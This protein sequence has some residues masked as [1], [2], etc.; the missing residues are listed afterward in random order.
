MQVDRLI[1]KLKR[2][3]DADF[4]S[5]LEL[6]R[7]A[8]CETWDTVLAGVR[9]KA[10]RYADRGEAGELEYAGPLKPRGKTA[11]RTRARVLQLLHLAPDGT[12]A[13]REVRNVAT[14]LVLRCDDRP[15]DLSWLANWPQLRLVH[16][17]GDATVVG[18][19]PQVTELCVPS[20]GSSRDALRELTALRK[21]L[22]YGAGGAGL[23][24][25]GLIG[26]LESLQVMSESASE[27][28]GIGAVAVPT[29]I[30][31]GA[32]PRRMSVHREVRDLHILDCRGLRELA[33]A[34][35]AVVE[36]VRQ[37]YATEPTALDVGALPALRELHVAP[38][39]DPDVSSLRGA[40]NLEVL[41]VGG[42][43]LRSLS[44]LSDSAVAGLREISVID[45]SVDWAGLASCGRLHTVIAGKANWWDAVPT[46]QELEGL[47]VLNLDFAE[48]EDTYPLRDLHQLTHISMRY[49]KGFM[50][51]DWLGHL[52]GL[53]E[54]DL[55]GSAM[56]RRDLSPKLRKSGVR[57]IL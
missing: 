20:L 47:R 50:Q 19:A 38:F 34:E 18:A 23:E 53:Q 48:I 17:R 36:R 40:P 51:L 27:L 52:E 8:D 13:A 45:A 16:V 3:D 35:D 21:L 15:L 54:L 55:T 1:T 41:R 11:E 30:V 43:S 4:E 26:S 29:L 12:S 14:S 39:D 33:L 5:A 6:L 57:V 56:K 32:F 28:D 24:A 46:L 49:C 42:P 25:L 7:D 2:P 9:W 22:V 37:W 10:S 31:R 44:G